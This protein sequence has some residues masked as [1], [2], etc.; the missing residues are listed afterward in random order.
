MS[1]RVPFAPAFSHLVYMRVFEGCNLHCEHCFIPK[2]P[3]KMT[4]EDVEREALAILKFARPGQHILVQWH[5]GEPT[6]FGAAWLEE[7]MDRVE[8]SC[9]ELTFS[10][11]IQTN[12]MTYSPEWADLY[13]RR[14]GGNVG[15]SWDPK[16]RLLPGGRAETNALYEEKF[17]AKLAQLVADGLDPY[18]VM[19]ATKTFFETFRD[20]VELFE[21]MVSI[22]V[23]KAH[24]ER[25]TETGYARD[26]WARLGVDNLTYSRSMGR[27]LRSYEVWR[28]NERN[29]ELLSLSPF[30]GLF[31]SI[32]NMNRG[33][34][35]YGCWSGHC[36][37]KFHTI[38]AGGYKVGCTALTSEIENTNASNS[39]SFVKGFAETRKERRIINCVDCPYRSICSSGCLAL[40]MDD[41]SGECSGGRRMFEA[42]ALVVASREAAE[43][44]MAR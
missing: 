30:D 34:G 28:R 20:P 43:G 5:G 44:R 39:L 36:D 7:A 18:L 11:G 25:L 4:L 17:F 26:N 38:D 42:A 24:I 32:E 37:T 23:R 14:F 35:G 27:I 40:S 6:M 29:G 1:A 9:P 2:N 10:H 31:S 41:G 3:K 8:R 12:L 33:E 22:G 19:T 16:I 15:V 13:R 21:K